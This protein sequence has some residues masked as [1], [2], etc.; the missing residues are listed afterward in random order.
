[1]RPGL[2]SGRLSN[3]VGDPHD[4][5]SQMDKSSSRRSRRGRGRQPMHPASHT[6]DL[7]KLGRDEEI[8]IDDTGPA[9][10]RSGGIGAFFRSIFSRS[11]SSSQRRHPHHNPSSGGTPAHNTS[12]YSSAAA[13]AAAAT[14]SGR[15]GRHA[16]AS[17]LGSLQSYATSTIRASNTLPAC[18]TQSSTS[19]VFTK[20]RVLHKKDVHDQEMLF[21]QQV[22][23]NTLLSKQPDRLVYPNFNVADFGGRE[24][25]A[26]DVFV[27]PH[28]AIRWEI[29]DLY[30]ILSSM[31]KR[32]SSLMYIDLYEFSEYWEAFEVFISQYFEVEDQIVFPFMLN[33][34]SE[35][36]DLKRYHKVVNYN[37]EKLESMLYDIGNTLEEFNND[38][39]GNDE[40]VP[41]L[42]KQLNEYLPKLLDYML[43]Q[44]NVL[45][46]VFKTYCD[47][48][49]RQMLNRVSANFIIRAVNGRN[50]IAILTRWIEDSMI[51]QVW[52][53]E[54]LSSRAQVSHKKWVSQLEA[55]HIDI[56]KRFQRRMRSMPKGQGNLQQQQQL[57]HNVLADRADHMRVSG[58]KNSFKTATRKLINW[59]MLVISIIVLYINLSLLLHIPHF[60]HDIFILHILLHS[61]L[62]IWWLFF[63]GNRRQKP[64]WHNAVMVRVL[65]YSFLKWKIFFE[66]W[67]GKTALETLDHANVLR[68]EQLKTFPNQK[69]KWKLKSN[70]ADRYVVDMIQLGTQS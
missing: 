41:K 63:V 18:L 58:S 49:D 65:I 24:T 51:L 11:D 21:S 8:G 62:T 35:C 7:G 31:Q 42:Y 52:K 46:S 29:M 26:S 22:R 20:K 10:L 12:R 6:L 39:A 25:W 43:Q 4:P 67:K 60:V 50:G 14:S 36:T 28:N 37:R 32:W 64:T 15:L 19:D 5:A 3:H 59:R 44:E 48:E 30:T 40:L 57:K 13:V 33:V 53:N 34:A 17:S 56:A 47:P 70:C 9:Q 38:D 68:W 61:P 2:L 45:P 66:V 27:L 55:G 16:A 69:S 23:D 54:N 1:M